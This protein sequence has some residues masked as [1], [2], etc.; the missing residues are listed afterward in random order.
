MGMLMDRVEGAYTCWKFPPARSK[1]YLGC[2][3]VPENLKDFPPHP[4]HRHRHR[5]YR[6][7]CAGECWGP[8]DL[9]SRVAA[10]YLLGLLRLEPLVAMASARGTSRGWQEEGR[11]L[12]G[13][14]TAATGTS[15]PLYLVCLE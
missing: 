1:S 9:P 7:S 13:Y 4:V 3:F 12:T 6:V 2:G 15:S 10:G 11:P 5:R 8:H 14:G